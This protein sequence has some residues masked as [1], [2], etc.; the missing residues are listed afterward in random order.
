VSF[1]ERFTGFDEEA[2]RAFE[3]R[4]WSS[5]LFNMERMAV[6]EQLRVI[7]MTVEPALL[8]RYPFKWEV[9]TH[10]PSVFNGKRVSELT[11]YFTRNDEQQKSLTPLLDSRIALPD[12]ISDAGEHHRHV[13]LGVR[14]D[15][16]GLEVGLMLHSTAWLDV[17]NLLNRCRVAE[18]SEQLLSLLRGAPDGAVFCVGPGVDVP[19]PQVTSQ[20]L[21]RLEQSVLNN[22]FLIL[23]GRQYPA[24]DQRLRA[25]GFPA[26]VR[27]PLLALYPLWDFVAWRPASDFLEPQRVEPATAPVAVPALS[28][29]SRVR[30]TE[31]VL[32][33]REGVVVDMDHKGGLRVLIG[34]LNVR[35]AARSVLPL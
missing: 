10:V 1:G 11:L 27:D 23:V 9:T 21:E 19:A 6:R 12:Q 31:G 35:T 20:D 32:A 8:A 17:M 33:G 29:G 14:I 15:G 26:E 16:G 34:R 5:N 7:G 30:L 13:T 4:K 22:T 28:L 3:P 18:E 24:G 2:F 25:A